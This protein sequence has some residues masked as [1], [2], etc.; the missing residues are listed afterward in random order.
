MIP[1]SRL[2]GMKGRL[3]ACAIRHAGH[4]LKLQ[5]SAKKLLLLITD[6]EPADI[7]VR[8]PQYLR[9]D[10]KRLEEMA[11]SGMTTFCISLTHEQ[12]V[13]LRVFE[14]LHRS[15]SCG[16]ATRKLPSLYAGL[17]R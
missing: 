15:G 10:T 2:A 13:C 6:G 8:D 7:D 11:C 3:L 4:Y 17:T 16:T 14:P 5:K 1:K 12:T 9:Y